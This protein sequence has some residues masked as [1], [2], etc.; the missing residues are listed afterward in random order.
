MLV[1]ESCVEVEDAVAD[2]MEAEVTRLDHAGM[3]WPDR[4]LIGV[5]PVH[6]HRPRTE[7]EVVVDER[8]QRLMTVEDHAVKIGRL[9]LVPVRRRDEVDDRGDVAVH[10]L[11][12]L[13]PNC[14]VGR[15]QR[16]VHP[17]ATRVQSCKA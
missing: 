14:A 12:A 5:V 17:G 16:R 13:E 3:D 8:A 10:D 4:D 2:D 15:D 7:I 6:G 11:G 1:E 9:A